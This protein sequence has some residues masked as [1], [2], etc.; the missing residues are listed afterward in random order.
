MA[1]L[2]R[3]LRRGTWIN[4]DP[5]YLYDIS[6]NLNMYCNVSRHRWKATFK[7]DYCSTP[8]R[9]ASTTAAVI[10]LILTCYLR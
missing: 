9:I 1:A 2:F 4:D 3:K 5:Y 10:L 7:H 8:W 6:N